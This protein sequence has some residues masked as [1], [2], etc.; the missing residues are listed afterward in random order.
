VRTYSWA[1]EEL[2]SADER[3]ISD[4]IVE[5]F[6]FVPEPVPADDLWP[7]AGYPDHGPDRD[8]PFIRVYQPLFERTLAAARA[9]GVGPLLTGDKGDETVGDWVFDHV[10]MI[11]SGR[12]LAAWREIGVQARHSGRSVRSIVRRDV[13]GMLPLAARVRAAL[14]RRRGAGPADAVAR[15]VPG[16]IR[17]AWA[18]R[19]GLAERLA[20]Q[21]AAAQRGGARAARYQRI[22]ARVGMLDPV[23]FARD[24]QRFGL[25]LR[26]P[27]SDRRLASFVLAV[28]QWVVQRPS[29]PKRIVR[30]A[31]RG[32]MP[33][34]ALR[35]ASKIEPAA[36]FER[37][38][39]ERAR[40]TALD[41]LTN[42]QLAARGF[43]D[44]A[45]LR[46]N[47]EAVHRGD[48]RGHD[49][50]WALTMEMWLRRYWS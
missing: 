38:F 34:A 3:H 6:G 46:S 5:R 22:F 16:F 41:L 36:L 14:P 40:E 10:G 49:P 35:G 15:H 47:Y 20:E 32:I 19:I 48:G 26:N 25:E 37:G 30:R 28:P 45:A 21:R 1:F 44:E 18:Q 13:L 11:A 24:C 42:G 7:L 23:P 29:E 43:V 2:T 31:M 39:S 12:P 33:D 4:G 8:D 17:P 27:W 50:W 9:H